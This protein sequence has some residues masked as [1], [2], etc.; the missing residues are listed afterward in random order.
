MTCLRKFRR[1]LDVPLTNF[2]I[3]LVLT[4]SDKCVLFNAAAQAMIFETTDTKFYV[5]VVTLSTQDNSLLFQKLKWG[6][7]IILQ[8]PNQYLDYL[9][10][11]SF[12]V[13]NR[14]FLFSFEKNTDRTVHIKHYLPTVEIKDYNV[15]I[16][17]RNPFDQPLKIIKKHTITL[18]S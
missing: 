7:K 4:W 9:V 1:T 15:T 16:D 5:P 10:D 13:V 3:Y 18:K 17:G 11:L 12:Q 14:L 6:F 2:E 8:A